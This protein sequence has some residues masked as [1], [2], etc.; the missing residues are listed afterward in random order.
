[1]KGLEFH[2]QVPKNII[3][4]IFSFIFTILIGLWLTPYLLKHLGIIAYGF[5][6]L[7]MFLS[8]YVSVIV[9]SINISI[10][11]F[12][13]ISLQ[14]NKEIESNEIFNTSLIIILFFILLQSLIMAIL[15][16]DIRLFFN[17]PNEL[18][19]DLKWLFG[20]T[21]LGFSISL[22]R[23][24]F[25]TSLFA[26]NRLDIL[27]IIDI[28][29]NLVRVITIVILFIYDEPSLKYVGIANLLASI[30]AF[31]PTLYFYKLYT[32]KLKINIFLF[33]RQRVSELSKMSTW[34][35]INQVG[36]L[37]LGNLDLY[38]VNTLLG[39]KATGEYAIILQVTTLFKTMSGLLGGVLAPVI[40]IYYTNQEHD[41]LKNILMLTSK[42]MA[43][44]M[45]IPLAIFIYFS[46]DLISIW[47]GEEFRYLENILSFSLLSL[48]L[49]IPVIPLF[50]ANIAYNKIKLPAILTILFGLFNIL[51]IY[52]LII[53]TDLGLWSIV[54]AKLIYEFIYNAIFIPIY[55]SKI[56]QT[57]YLSF[58]MIPITSIISFVMAYII[59]GFFTYYLYISTF[60][61]ILFFSILLFIFLF[62]LLFFLFI[63]KEERIFL[64]KR[65]IK[66]K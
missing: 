25:G 17:I 60:W 45:I 50:S 62:P 49:S 63:S 37:L 40:M 54:L 64:S 56:I 43:I 13:L 39:A 8:Q 51:C 11:R 3:V 10:G 57:Q 53:Y 9:N 44:F 46:G 34:I 2:K 18:I 24:V 59:I 23:S 55:V 16:F 27:R 21:F 35:L 7:A 66:G 52:L 14:K 19:E 4:N 58:L 61:E 32:P 15:L 31:I 20:L 30:I 29:Q 42:I 65:Y 41:K 26:Y 1:M 22:F 38:L 28:F 48:I 33:R 36:V 5:I 12:L 47:L 6:P